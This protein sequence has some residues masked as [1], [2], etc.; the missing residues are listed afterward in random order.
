MQTGNGY[1]EFTLTPAEI[2]K[3]KEQVLQELDKVDTY[4]G[5]LDKAKAYYKQLIEKTNTDI[6]KLRTAIKTGQE[7]IELEIVYN[8]TKIGYKTVTRKDNGYSFETEM[9][10]DEERRYPPEMFE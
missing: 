5:D 6:V 1:Q 8:H 7:M 2:Q 4:K 9:E 10:P 3:R